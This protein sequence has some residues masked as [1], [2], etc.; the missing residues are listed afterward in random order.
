[1]ALGFSLDPEQKNNI[2]L[3]TRLVSISPSMLM[4]YPELAESPIMTV[5]YEERAPDIEFAENRGIH[6]SKLPLVLI[7]RSKDSDLSI[8]VF[9]HPDGGVKGHLNDYEKIGFLHRGYRLN[10]QGRV[11][12][13]QMAY[14]YDMYNPP[15][16]FASESIAKVENW[17]TKLDEEYPDQ[18]IARLNEFL[19]RTT[20]L[21]LFDMVRTLTFISNRE[22]IRDLEE[23]EGLRTEEF[24]SLK[25]AI[26]I[27]L[28][29]SIIELTSDRQVAGV[30]G[31]TWESFALGPDEEALQEKVELLPPV[32]AVNRAESILSPNVLAEIVTRIAD[33][34]MPEEGNTEFELISQITP[35]MLTK[36]RE[37]VK[38]Y[39]GDRK[40]ELWLEI[41][42][43]LAEVFPLIP[44]LKIKRMIGIGNSSTQEIILAP[45]VVL[46]R[47]EL[48]Y[49]RRRNS[50]NDKYTVE[51][52]GVRTTRV[53]Y[54][55]DNLGLITEG[56]ITTK[57]LSE[58]LGIGLRQVRALI[59]TATG[60]SGLLSGAN[61]IRNNREHQIILSEA[62]KDFLDAI[63]KG[64]YL[65]YTELGRMYRID[66]K[67]IKNYIEDKLT[68]I[69]AT[70][71]PKRI[72]SNKRARVALENLKAQLINYNGILYRSRQ[73]ALFSIILSL[74]SDYY[75]VQG[76]NVNVR[77]AHGTK[78]YDFKL[79]LDLPDGTRRTVIIELGDEKKAIGLHMGNQSAYEPERKK[80]LVKDYPNAEIIFIHNLGNLL[81]EEFRSII[82][83][84]EIPQEVLDLLHLVSKRP[85]KYQIDAGTEVKG[86]SGLVDALNDPVKFVGIFKP[87]LNRLLKVFSHMLDDETVVQ[88]IRGLYPDISENNFN[89]MVH[90]Y[91]WLATKG[92]DD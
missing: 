1:M 9:G 39:Y 7:I 13:I 19:F 6:L 58:K 2:I 26:P 83:I 73:E 34:L 37:I 74:Y 8:P 64:E 79:C 92:E 42:S 88:Q 77:F 65:G 45:E 4:R 85:K 30:R 47:K 14:K 35:E 71:T 60:E 25:L 63:K 52:D 41:G 11:V 50:I 48:A 33:A 67:T 12:P 84:K 72:L 46:K 36:V 10:E 70:E 82:G 61:K 62:W 28:A 32:T 31:I 38:E 66:K 57:E 3:R 23:T 56:I 17:V 51:I 54:I 78:E 76:K 5:A 44:L 24:I 89:H 22:E 68:S 90:L 43:L 18:D 59:R 16:V 69:G 15:N 81:N 80:L 55:L 40:S 87:T 86:L 20:G 27:E 91:R 53:Q 21:N 29:I 75:P 49:T